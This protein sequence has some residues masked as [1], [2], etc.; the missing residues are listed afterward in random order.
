MPAYLDP[1]HFD[2]IRA[3]APRVRLHHTDVATLLS[4]KAAAAVDRYVLLDAQDWMTDGQLNRLWGEITRT[5]APGARVI[6]R[7]AAEQRLLPGRL[8]PALLDQ[9]CHLAEAS[10]EFGR[11]DRIGGLARHLSQTPDRVNSPKPRIRFL[12]RIRERRDRFA[13]ATGQLKLRGLPHAHV[14]VR[15]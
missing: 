11:R 12:E 1:L 13:A 9:W 2:T 10:H 5:A 6:F 7:T 14:L 15:E 4:R 3:N 8:S